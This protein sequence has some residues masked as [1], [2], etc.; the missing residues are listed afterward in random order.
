MIRKFKRLG[1][2]VVE[3]QLIDGN[4][5]M[6]YREA[7]YMQMFAHKCIPHLFGVKVTEKQLALVMEFIGEGSQSLTVHKLLCSPPKSIQLEMCMKDWL[8]ISFDI[9]DALD[10]IHKKGYLHCDIKTD[11]VL[12]FHNRGYLIDFG[13]VQEMARST[14]KKYDKKYDHIAPEVLQ[15]NPPNSATDVYSVGRVFLAIG[16]VTEIPLLKQLGRKSTSP[17]SKQRPTLTSMLASLNL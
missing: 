17:D 6:L 16:R 12:V 15:G 13:K 4:I 14:S 2:N 7:K 3:K 1:I 9:L 10:F 8:S 5:D 11:N